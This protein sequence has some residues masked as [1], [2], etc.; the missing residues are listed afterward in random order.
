[1]VVPMPDGSALMGLIGALSGAAIGAIA[2]IYGPLVL[3]KK[4]RHWQELA[5]EDD[6][7]TTRVTPF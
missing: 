3:K 4:E 6:Q 7:Y 5:R 1:M 2:A